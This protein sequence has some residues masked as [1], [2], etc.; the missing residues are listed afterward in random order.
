MKANVLNLDGIDF[1]IVFDNVVTD[2]N[3]TTNADD[4]RILCSASKES[5][6]EVRIITTK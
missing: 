2:L 3:I 1:E 6:Y 5:I 4:G